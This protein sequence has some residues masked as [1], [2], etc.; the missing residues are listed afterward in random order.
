MILCFVNTFEENRNKHLIWGFREN[1]SN[2]Q[3]PK[4]KSPNPQIPQ[5]FIVLG[6]LQYSILGMKSG[7]TKCIQS[8]GFCLLDYIS[9]LYVSQHTDCNSTLLISENAYA[10]FH[11]A[12]GNIDLKHSLGFH[13]II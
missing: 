7:K 4:F 10:E 12:I 1:G 6:L 11:T 9:I 2:P 5:D 8:Q 3:I 13:T